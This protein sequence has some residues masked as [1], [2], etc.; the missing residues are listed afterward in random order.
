[1][2][3]VGADIGATIIKHL[4]GRMT[5]AMRSAFRMLNVG[6]DGTQEA[7]KFITT[8]ANVNQGIVNVTAF[9]LG[10]TGSEIELD[11]TPKEINEFADVSAR[12]VTLAGATKA[13]EETDNNKVFYLNKVDGITVTL[14]KLSEV[15]AGWSCKFIVK[16]QVTSNDYVITE[17]GTSETNKI[18]GGFDTGIVLTASDSPTSGGCTFITFVDSQT[19]AGDFCIF[20]TDGLSWFCYGRTEVL[21]GVTMT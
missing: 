7:S 5:S 21:A 17:D 12:G 1:M 19:V 4:P 2:A 3:Q 8:D 20:E 16:L 14:P 9:H 11:A 13:I 6:T 10:A 15:Y 18:R